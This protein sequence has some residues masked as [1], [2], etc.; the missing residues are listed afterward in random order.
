MSTIERTLARV[1][2]AIVPV[3]A[4]PESLDLEA[5]AEREPEPPRFIIQD[6][7][8]A[9]YA[10]L[11]AGHGGIGKSGVALHL[12]VCIAAGRAFFGLETERRRVLYL[13]CEDR[14]RVLHWRLTRICKHLTIDLGSLRGW[15]E[16]IDLVGSDAILF[17]KDPRTGA[18]FTPALGHLQERMREHQSEVLF[19]DGVA[20]TFAGNENS[21]GEVKR[22]VNR[23]VA[24]IP[25]DDG[26][27]VL[28]GHVAKPASTAGANGDGYSGSTGWHN[29][30]RARWYL[31]PETVQGEDGERAK[32]SGDLILELQKSNLGCADQSMRVTWDESEK[33]FIGRGITNATASELNRR[34]RLEQ[35]G[36]V[37]AIKS[38]A[39]NG[40]VIPVAMQGPRTAFHV[41]CQRPEFPDS[42]RNGTQA[43]RRFL[44]HLEW[45]RQSH[46]IEECEYRRSNRHIGAQIVLASAAKSQANEVRQCAT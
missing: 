41:L 12:A 3:R 30:A 39:D 29:S 15:L 44:R 18:T 4:W 36:I 26:A 20:D 31:Y 2:A 38:C 24:L 11:F 32:R 8:P 21:R 46:E 33:L 25:P 28:I 27:V 1:D 9:G 13:S 19:V 10:T 5:L 43:K 23:L 35:D 34:A 7:L 22:F 17:D 42:L 40:I 45:L 14:E 37:A 16:V 6:W